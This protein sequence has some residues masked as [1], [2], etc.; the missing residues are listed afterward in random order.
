MDK[1][2]I[3]SLLNMDIE[4]EHG[5]IIQYLTHAYSIG[6]GEISCEIE[7]IARDEMRHLDWLAE[8]V[9]ELGGK[10]SMVRGFMRMKGVKVVDWMKNDVLLEEDAINPYREQI[11]MISDKDVKRLLDRILSDELAHHEQFAHFVKKVKSEKLV[12]HR[13][14]RK[15]KTT[16]FINKSIHNEYT[17][18]LQY[19][20]HSYLTRNED[21]KDEL[22]DQAINEMQHMGWLSEELVE[23][24]S[25]PILE[26]GK[27]L[28][29]GTTAKMLESDI[30]VERDVAAEYKQGIVKIIKDPDLKKLI[31]R[32]H[33]HEVYHLEL[34]NKLLKK[35]AKK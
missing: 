15:D 14:K 24:S 29:P 22:Q 4:N 19:L 8:K 32:I 1:K 7:G 3:I 35:E 18:I 31:Q 13:G 30:K 28:K 17:E 25:A 33:G 6:E 21:A 9:V 34:F 12:D 27:I 26:H 10:P 11:K 16:D 2:E 5:A 23:A 20:L